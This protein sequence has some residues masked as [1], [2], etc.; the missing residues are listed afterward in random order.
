VRRARSPGSNPPEH[1]AA[2]QRAAGTPR[3]EHPGIVQRGG[4]GPGRDE[5]IRGRAVG[6]SGIEP[7]QPLRVEAE[8]LALALRRERR[9]SEP[10]LVLGRDLERAQRHDLGLGR[11]VPDRIGAPEHA[12]LPDPAQQLA[13]H[14]R[15]LV[16]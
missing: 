3:V 1:L 9:V 14:V 12:V 5:R 10:L 13:E 16:G 2:R 8:H 15:G 6:R 11:S 4:G 7:E